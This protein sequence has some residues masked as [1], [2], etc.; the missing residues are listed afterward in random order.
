MAT[1]IA[2]YDRHMDQMAKQMEKYEVGE[3]LKFSF[4]KFKKLKSIKSDTWQVKVW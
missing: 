1:L 4:I 3:T 2:E